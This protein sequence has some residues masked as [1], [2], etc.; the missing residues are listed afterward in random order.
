MNVNHQWI[1]G[2]W[3]QTEIIGGLDIK[4]TGQALLRGSCPKKQRLTRLNKT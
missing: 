3:I 4:K 1:F 2:E